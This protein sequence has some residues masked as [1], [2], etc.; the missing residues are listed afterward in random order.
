MCLVQHVVAVNPLASSE[1]C[2]SYV[3]ERSIAFFI[4]FDRILDKLPGLYQ[5]LIGSLNRQCKGKAKRNEQF[6]SVQCGDGSTQVFFE[7]IRADNDA[8]PLAVRLDGNIDIFLLQQ[9]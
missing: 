5:R 4:L 3:S 7:F 9:R 6:P 1:H 2:Y 8:V